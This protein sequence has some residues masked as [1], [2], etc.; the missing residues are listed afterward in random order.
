MREEGWFP[1]IP[2]YK[3]DVEAAAKRY[4]EAFSHAHVDGD[5]RRW[6]FIRLLAFDLYAKDK[7]IGL[8]GKRGNP[9][10][11]S[12]DALNY[13]DQ[14][15][16][17]GRTPEGLRCWV[18]DVIGGAGGPNPVPQW[19][20]QHDPVAS[21]GAWVKPGTAPG[22][23]PIPVPPPVGFPYPDENTT[24]K[25]YQ[26]RVR[27]AYN[28]AGRPFPDPNDSDAF[29]WFSRYGFDCKT[30]PEPDV[31]NKQIADLRKALGLPA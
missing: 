1:V 24:V 26:D 13:L 20:V 30:Q 25:A 5:P 9:N 21:S 28:D 29:R 17:P 7:N 14:I 27:K 8:N 12:M 22:P 11:L 16:G 4:P 15:D 3:A 31:A 10:D 19:G 6:D 2:D 23:V 18:V